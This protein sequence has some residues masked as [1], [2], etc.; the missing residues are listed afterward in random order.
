MAQGIGV[1]DGPALHGIAL[2]GDGARPVEGAVP[3][4]RRIGRR[5]ILSYGFGAVAYGVKDNGFATFLLLFYN[6]VIGLPS[7]S[8]GF[9]VMCALI[10]DAFVDPA[11]GFLSDRTR[12]RWGRRHPWMIGSAVP[13]AAGWVLLW[14]PPAMSDSATLAWLFV[15]AV[16][17]RTAVSAYEVPSMA[18]TPELSA[19][20]DERTR[21]M[22]YRY[23]FGWA[24]GLGMLVVA[25][26][27]FLRPEAGQV[28][29]LLNRSGYAGFAIAGAVLMFAAIIV[30]AWGTRHEIPRLP[31]AP[32]RRETIAEN[33]RELGQ[34]VRNRAFVTL[35]AA[36]LC[37]YSAQG[38]GFALS[39]YLYTFVWRFSANGFVILSGVLFAGVS[40]AFLV[41][42]RVARRI[43][44][45][46]AAAG[47]MLAASLLLAAP[48]L[49]RLAG[50]FPP[51]DDPLMFPLLMAIY[52]CNTACSVSS[53]MLG[54]SMMADVVEHSEIQT[55]RR[56]EGVFFAG[57]FFVQKC[58]GGLGIFASGLILAAVG[59][60][61]QATPG[62]VAAGTIDR[63]TLSFALIYLALG[64][65]AA[66]L[67]SRFPFGRA[68]H[69]ARVAALA[70]G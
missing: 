65:A 3:P 52:V 13:I 16:V 43:G 59:F 26:A 40:V 19:D 61:A 64:F 33:F 60:P 30:S 6:Q 39:N 35:M 9:V 7:A 70:Q 67:Y 66:L 36:G 51:P 57:G 21:I 29:G 28:S 37:F 62:A 17:V 63:L 47:F 31:R 10:F 69:D 27:V 56:S 46:R 14:N 38:I 2:A 48:Y 11:V 42:P 18:L 24:G 5:S 58:T 32:D 55:G 54:A 34:T 53:T 15:L 45:P 49:L 68:E 12:S 25:Y 23:L 41:A 8:V 44:K 50:L 20:Y 22:A 4:I 1:D